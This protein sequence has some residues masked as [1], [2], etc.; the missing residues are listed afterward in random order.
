MDGGN[1]FFYFFN[2]RLERVNLRLEG[3]EFRL[4]IGDFSI[5]AAKVNYVVIYLFLEVLDLLSVLRKR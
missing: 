2:L 4:V 5:V 1:G 3:E